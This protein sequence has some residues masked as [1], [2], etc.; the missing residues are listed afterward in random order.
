MSSDGKQLESPVAFVEKVL[1]PEGFEVKTN[2][3]VFN[4][5]GIQTIEVRGKVGTLVGRRTRFKFGIVTAGS[6]TRFTTGTIEFASKE[7]IELREVRS[8]A[9]EE[10]QDKGHGTAPSHLGSPPRQYHR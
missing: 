10:F 5:E 4:D 7:G 9:P 1:V 8:L 6:T 3:G 2:E